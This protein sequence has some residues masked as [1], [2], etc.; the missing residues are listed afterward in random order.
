MNDKSS[1]PDDV[2]PLSIDVQKDIDAACNRFEDE[3]NSPHQP[4]IEDYL[5]QCHLAESER[6]DLL[7]ELVK[8]DLECQ[9]RRSR[10]ATLHQEPEGN[11]STEA[12]ILDPPLI[13]EYLARFPVLASDSL[14]VS[15]IEH[16]FGIRHAYGD[17]P[18]TQ[19]YL[20]RFP[21]CREIIPA[22]QRLE[23]ELIRN[24]KQLQRSTR[25]L[26]GEGV[27]ITCPH[28][29][30]AVEI[31]IDSSYTEVTCS[32]C[33]SHFDMAEER[34]GT[35]TSPALKRVG[36]FDLISRIGVGSFGTVWK[37]HDTKLDRTVAIKIPR[38]SHLEPGHAESF[39]RE[40]R[41]AAQLRHPNIV[42]VYEIG[43]DHDV[44]YI[45]TDFVRGVPLSEWRTC[46]PVSVDQTA[47]LC[48][49]IAIALQHAHDC[50]VIHRDLK[51]ANIMI[52]D[53]NQPHILDF[54]LAKRVAGEVSMTLSGQ[55]LGTPAYMSPE[56]ASGHG[57]RADHRSDVFSLGVILYQLI[58]GE[59]PFRGDARTL[60]HKVLFDEVVIPHERKQA[61]P[62]DIICICLKCLQKEPD[63][64][65]QSS[66]DLAGDLRRFL[67][68]EV[69]S[70]RPVNIAAQTWRW[71]KRRPLVASA[72]VAAILACVLLPWTIETRKELKSIRAEQLVA[73]GKDH[74]GKDRQELAERDFVEAIKLDPTNASAHRQIGLIHDK[75]HLWQDAV[76]SFSSAIRHHPMD[77]EL[78]Q[79][80]ARAY[81]ALEDYEEAISDF[82]KFNEL[83]PSHVHDGG[84]S[85]W[86]AEKDVHENQTTVE[87]HPW[88]E[89]WIT[90]IE[91][92]WRG[93][94]LE[95]RYRVAR[96]DSD[97]F[98]SHWHYSRTK[99][100]LLE[101][102][103]TYRAE[104]FR[105]HSCQA[106]IDPNQAILYQPVFRIIDP[107]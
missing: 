73:R 20:T 79:S 26:A 70:A 32:S 41:T 25:Q 9:W 22:L 106:C 37:A 89:H 72:A 61:I 24:R 51:P 28:C 76:N 57:Y 83:V 12:N 14:Q 56:Q 52:D 2:D 50:G 35:A 47:E 98:I 11:A 23:V 54:G 86:Y 75:N 36:H 81:A 4:R 40:A 15:L 5:T 1:E 74:L 13:E 49:T 100:Q 16:E 99:S 31:V 63:K 62:K 60:L 45:V 94:T 69:V 102:C 44:V 21:K 3:W 7:V 68:G 58:T 43:Q 67:Q 33:G 46:H 85:E 77:W 65:Y 95:L 91:A 55:V 66:L 39:L 84:F 48:A 34:T 27:H 18:E 93:N 92:R 29:C 78:Y 6:Q 53:K 71:C 107:K 19:E 87:A 103:N 90:D 8:I 105:L 17:N 80:R 82:K 64:R 104:G 30:N 88:K 97:P 38:R 96:I 42:R 10:Q 101:L 59:L